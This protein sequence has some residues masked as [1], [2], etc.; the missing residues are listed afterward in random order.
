M[1]M[2]PFTRAERR[3]S[4]IAWIAAAISFVVALGAI[5]VWAL[6][7]GDGCEAGP[8]EFA[9][10]ARVESDAM[11][12]TLARG[13]LLLMQRRYYCR[14]EPKRGDVA[15]LAPPQGQ[16][17]PLI[18]RIVGLPGDQVELRRGQLVLNG[19]PVERDWLESTIR[20][21][22][23]G[24]PHHATH[25]VEGLPEGPSYDIQVGDPD[26]SAETMAPLTVPAEHYFMLGDD[27]DAATDSR[28]FGALARPMIVDRPWLILWGD[29]WSRVGHWF[30]VDSESKKTA[31]GD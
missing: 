9:R 17:E 15:V 19:E 6:E 23:N 18:L 16:S 22:E 5:G 2:R 14:I 13:D 7:P 12:P 1:S 26:V 8:S 10:I 31:V 25:F 27:R 11:L 24:E 4:R 3:A 21:D 29:S 28:S 20:T 30:A